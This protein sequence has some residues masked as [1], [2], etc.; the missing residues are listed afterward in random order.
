[1]RSPS[2]SSPR[3]PDQPIELR[4]SAFSRLLFTHPGMA[5]VWLLLRLFVG[6]T[7][8]SSGLEKLGDSKWV[9]AEAGKAVTTF[10]QGALKKTGGEMPDV[11]GWYARFI[12]HVALPN[13]GVFSYVVTFGELAVGAAL[14][15]GLLTGIAAFFGLLMNFSYL[16]AGTL[17]NNPLLVFLGLLL[18]LAWRVAGWWGLDRWI[19]PRWWGWQRRDDP[20]LD[21][22]SVPGR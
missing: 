12:E 4:A 1:M 20:A 3:L 18:I 8:L 14:I 16:L 17:S 15:L 13:A 2:L 11:P 22:G 9:G 6:W 10:L 19:L 7:W 21:T 5:P